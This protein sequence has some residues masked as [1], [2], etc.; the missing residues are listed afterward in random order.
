MYE[1]LL[2]SQLF[3]LDFHALQIIKMTSKFDTHLDHKLFQ[4]HAPYGPSMTGHDLLKS[5]RALVYDSYQ[6]LGTVFFLV[7]KWENVL[8]A[9]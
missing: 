1:Y 8:L 7:A 6:A 2:I 9:A 4:C 5:C 3:T